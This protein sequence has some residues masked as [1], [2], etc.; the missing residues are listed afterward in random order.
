M[1][2][3]LLIDDDAIT[4]TIVKGI[5]K[6]DFSLVGC[7]SLSEATSYFDKGGIPHLVIID[8]M[9]PDGDGIALCSKMRADPRLSSVPIIFLSSLKSETDKVSGL[10]AGADDYVSKPCSVLELKARI[11][12]RLRTDQSRI[13]FGLI[14]VDLAS[15][16]TFIQ[17]GSSQTEL[18]LTRKEFKLLITLMQS[19]DQIFSRDQ[20]LTRVWGDDTNV[21]DRVV[22]TSMSHLRKKISGAGVSIEALRGEGY[23][24]VLNSKAQA[25]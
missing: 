11:H 12:A 21:S 20:L 13:A 10:F 19:P 25:A 22:D 9:L 8:R 24:L 4:H 17:N 6:D 3:I 7:Y 16:R 1:R 18:E 15:H 5:V 2:Q 14:T 23:R